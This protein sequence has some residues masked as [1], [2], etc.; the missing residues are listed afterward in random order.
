MRSQVT[1]RYKKALE[2]RQLREV[3][4][5]GLAQPRWRNKPMAIW[6]RGPEQR[7]CLALSV[8]RANT[9]S[10]QVP[11]GFS[12]TQTGLAK[13][14]I[15]LLGTAEVLLA[16]AGCGKQDFLP[17]ITHSR[18]VL[19]FLFVP[20]SLPGSCR[21]DVESE[22]EVVSLFLFVCLFCCY[23]PSTTAEPSSNPVRWRPSLFQQPFETW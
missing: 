4:W 21:K 22:L 10:L 16:R 23:F 20:G 18:A 1:F 11:L 6:L 14:S 13:T 8:Y 2:S 12:P 15:D 5:S 7:F 3:T 19:R 9:G 17:C